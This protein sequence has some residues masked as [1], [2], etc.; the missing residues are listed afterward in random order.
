LAGIVE[1]PSLRGRVHVFEDRVEAGEL[2]AEKLKGYG[3]RGDAYVLAIPAGGM[4][5]ANV[6]ARR[7]G[8]PLDVFIT[9]KIHIPWNMEAGFGAVSWDGVVLL[10][11]PL[12]AHLGLT[13][14]DVEACIEEER[15]AI[16]RRLRKFRDDRPFPDLE[17]KAVIVVDDGLA[18]GF[19]MLVTLRSL[20]RRRPGELVVAVPTASE[21]ALGLV[22]PEA[23]RVFCLNVRPGPVFAVADAYR[24]WHDLEDDDVLGLLRD[25]GL[26]P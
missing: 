17:G 9:R 10:N 11:E 14:E 3:G 18:S 6:I 2:L 22:A 4:Q 19:S 1:E 8:L 26:G 25:L 15:R 5:V 16:D 7:L 23:D 21:S 13:R 20:R 12:V 24:R